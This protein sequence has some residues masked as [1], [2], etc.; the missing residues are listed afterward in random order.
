MRSRAIGPPLYELVFAILG[1][2]RCSSRLGLERGRARP[3]PRV[4]QIRMSPSRP[5]DGGASLC[6]NVALIASRASGVIQDRSWLL[7]GQWL[8]FAATLI[9]LGL[10]RIETGL[11]G[12]PMP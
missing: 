12:K 9:A 6:G 1:S 5:L 7:T 4:D 11:G 8:R 2:H 3:R 10:F